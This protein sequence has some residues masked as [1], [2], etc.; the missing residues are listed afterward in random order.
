[1][2]LWHIIEILSMVITDL[3]LHKW[4]LLL[5]IARNPSLR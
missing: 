3:L 5:R 2:R 1:M 4:P